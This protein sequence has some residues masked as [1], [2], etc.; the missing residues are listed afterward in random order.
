MEI[1][2][3]TRGPGTH[4]ALSE[5]ARRR[6]ELR[7]VHRKDTV[8]YIAVRL[9][10][11]A[12]RRGHQDSYCVLRVQL[13]DLPATT[14]VDVG[15][16]AYATIDRAVDRVGRLVEAQLNGAAADKQD[17]TRMKKLAA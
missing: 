12:R 7:L 11:A 5:H 15:G 1:R 13:R 2:F 9:G 6:L 14:V 3:Q 17:S 4:L 16:N 8:A 10:D